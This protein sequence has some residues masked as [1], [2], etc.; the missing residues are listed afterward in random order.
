MS[1][2]VECK[3]WTIYDSKTIVLAENAFQNLRPIFQ[4]VI[5]SGTSHQKLGKITEEYARIHN[6][7][8]FPRV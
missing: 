8:A 3:V 2:K 7:K 5:L 1:N 6:W 4:K